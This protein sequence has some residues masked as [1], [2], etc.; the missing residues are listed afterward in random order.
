MVT[1]YDGW[2]RYCWKNFII[3]ALKLRTINVL[4]E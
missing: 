1:V 4:E 3:K 2:D